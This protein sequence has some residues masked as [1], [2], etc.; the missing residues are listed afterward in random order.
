[1]AVRHFAEGTRNMLVQD[2]SS[3]VTCFQEAC[4]LFDAKYGIGAPE[5]GDVYLQYG[6]ALLELARLETGVIDGVVHANGQL[7]LIII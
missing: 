5:C 4:K 2:Y 1:M 7:I 6:S 3:A